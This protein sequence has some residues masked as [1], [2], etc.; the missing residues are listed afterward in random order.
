MDEAQQLMDSLGMTEEDLS[1]SI[2]IDGFAIDSDDEEEAALEEKT[3]PTTSDA[4]NTLTSSDGVVVE[5]EPS[6]SSVE[7][8]ANGSKNGDGIQ[9]VVSSEKQQEAPLHPLHEDVLVSPPTPPTPTNTETTTT[10]TSTSI[11]PP[12]IPHNNSGSS[13]SF[14]FKAKTSLFASNLATFAQKAASQVADQIA[15]TDKPVVQP[16]NMIP[17]QQQASS[18]IAVELD[19]ETK[20]KLIQENVG[21]LLPGERVIMF[22]SN[23]VHVS[24]STRDY[25]GGTWCCCMTYYRMLLFPTNNS[26]SP[27]EEERIPPEWNPNVWSLPP[28]TPKLLQ[29]PLASIDK[30]EKSVYTTP[31][32]HA[33]MGLI[34]YG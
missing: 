4:V 23:L 12:P 15:T 18:L 3:T 26:P 29:I 32:N 22:L 27:K 16:P 11:E 24:D 25:T 6:A 9:L 8:E 17:E 34:I 5:K 10:T 1:E 28:S 20:A 19:N 31:T 30:V 7:K 33:L 13:S 14:D 2:V 21:P